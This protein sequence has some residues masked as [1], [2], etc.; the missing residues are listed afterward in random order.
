MKHLFASIISFFILI[1]ICRSQD[2]LHMMSPH[3]SLEKDKFYMPDK[4]SKEFFQAK[5]NKL[6][7]TGWVLLGTGVGLGVAGIITY[8]HVNHGNDWEEAGNVFG[9]IILMVT[10]SALTIASVP[11]FIRAGYYNR[12]AMSMSANLK[13]EPYQSGVA[14][15]QY[16]AIGLRI[17]L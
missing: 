9:G 2:S 3:P 14:V 6:N 15:K 1:G 5:H 13:F 11:V 16:P 8:D 4:N 7:T 17:S 12:K 10:G